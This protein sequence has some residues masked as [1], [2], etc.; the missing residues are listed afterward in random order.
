VSNVQKIIATDYENTMRTCTVCNCEMDEGF[1]TSEGT[2]ELYFCNTPCLRTEY[3]HDEYIELYNDG[4]A[5]WTDWVD[6][7]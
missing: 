1:L 6:E 2:Q 7:E 5:Y 3:T 4:L